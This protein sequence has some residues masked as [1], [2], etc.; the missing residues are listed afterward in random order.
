VTFRKKE[1]NDVDVMLVMDDTF[2]PNKAPL[3]ARGLF[4]HAVAQ[5]GYG[6]SG[7]AIHV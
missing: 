6:A 4:D 2:R 1:P 5:A 7:R 3:E